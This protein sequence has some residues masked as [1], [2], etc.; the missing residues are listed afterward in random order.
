[1]GITSSEEDAAELVPL[2]ESTYKSL[3]DAFNRVNTVYNTVDSL[4]QLMKKIL[5]LLRIRNL[6]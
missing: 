1:M 3:A 4:M 6:Q 5:H 2:H